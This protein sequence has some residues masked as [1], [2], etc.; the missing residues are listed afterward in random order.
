MEDFETLRCRYL[1]KK[2]NS[3]RRLFIIFCS[4]GLGSMI[5]ALFNWVFWYIAIPCFVLG[6]KKYKT[7]THSSRIRE[8]VEES[9]FYDI[10]MKDF[11]SYQEACDV[12]TQSLQN[13]CIYQLDTLYLTKDW[14]IDFYQTEVEIIGLHHIIWVYG[15]V[16]CGTA[17]IKGILDDTSEFVMRTG[18]LN[19]V[20]KLIQQNQRDALVGYSHHIETLMK[21]DPQDFVKRIQNGQYPNNEGKWL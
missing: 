2:I 14:I 3:E 4:I 11:S 17:Y 1:Y 21:K 15:V 13:D 9:Q 8:H 20:V 16:L 12:L 19:K 7:Y 5:L 18:E 6:Y 10:L